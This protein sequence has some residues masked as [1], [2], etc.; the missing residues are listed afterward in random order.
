[1][2][3]MA[4]KMASTFSLMTLMVLSSTSAIAGKNPPPPPS[5]PSY[6]VVTLIHMGDIHGH[7]LPRPNLR[8]E[9]SGRMEGGL[10]RMYTQIKDIRKYKPNALL[11]N[12]GDTLQGSGEALYSRGPQ[13]DTQ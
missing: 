7:T 6:K 11:V 9:A 10:A 3:H 12:T 1:M 4:M 8:N 2:R 13:N 5:A